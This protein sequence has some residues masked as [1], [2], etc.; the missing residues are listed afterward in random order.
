MQAIDGVVSTESFFVLEAHKLAY[1]WGVGNVPGPVEAVAGNPRALLAGAKADEMEQAGEGDG[2]LAGVRVAD[3]S[4]VLAGPYA[5]MM[6]A[7]FGADVIK[8][9]SPDGDDTRRWLPAGRRARRLH[10]LRQRQPQQARGRLRL[11]DRCRPG[12]G[13]PAGRIAPTS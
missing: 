10:L 11:H 7:D 5:T 8:I 2:P 13:P 12:R 1:G 4:R 3:F 9:E 6:L